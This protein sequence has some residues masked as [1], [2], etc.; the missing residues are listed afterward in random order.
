M[1][2]M[3]QRGDSDFHTQKMSPGPPFNSFPGFPVPLYKFSVPKLPLYTQALVSISPTDLVLFF[4]TSLPKWGFSSGQQIASQPTGPLSLSL[5]S[6]QYIWILDFSSRVSGKVLVYI[7]SAH[8]CF[9]V[10]HLTSFLNKP[11]C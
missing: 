3:G 1:S 6:P 9:R 10:L 11:F 4:H 5:D 2:V 7:Y 8:D